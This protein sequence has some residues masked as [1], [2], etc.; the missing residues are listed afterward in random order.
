[1]VRRALL[2]GLTG[3]AVLCW[4]PSSAGA[5]LAFNSARCD[6]GGFS[7]GILTNG[8]CYAG[9]FR[10]R[11]DGTHQKRLTTGGATAENHPQ[12]SPNFG[13]Y[14][15]AWSPDG[16][17]VLFARRTGNFTYRLWTVG[18]NG[19]NEQEFAA[20]PPP[21]FAS[22]EF[23]S[24]APQGDRIA[25]VAGGDD[26]PG[27]DPGHPL[28]VS[29]TDGSN[30]V[31]LTPDGWD[32]TSPD[33]T[34]DGR[35]IIF[36]GFPQGQGSSTLDYGLY[37]VDADGSNLHPLTFM[38]DLLIAANG[39]SISPDGKYLA[40]TRSG[41]V[42]TMRL[43]DGEVVNRSHTDAITPTWSPVGP[44]IFFQGYPGNPGN[45][46]QLFS[47]D[48]SDGTENALTTPAESGSAPDWG[49]P[50]DDGPTVHGVTD[51]AAPSVVTPGDLPSAG[52]ASFGNARVS[53]A[54][55]KLSKIRFLAVDKTGIRRIDVA[56]GRRVNGGCR[57]V[58]GGGKLGAVRSCSR[59]R[60]Y[61]VKSIGA[62]RRRTDDLA[63]G[64]YEVR[65]RTTDVKGHRTKHPRRHLVKVR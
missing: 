19:S 35:H 62:W 10:M 64:T 25:F 13:D 12:G 31:K 63:K 18:A 55:T 7:G 29:G 21:G 57:F 5:E 6:Q 59:P 4:L 43:A 39:M 47:V 42:Y 44:T 17:S 22:Q 60:Y 15:P 46:S 11:D 3:L 16:K 1:V 27:E 20:G 40:F 37:Q 38:G 53:A 36:F 45:A 51:R 65:F 23:P 24:W 48:I 49:D 54:G 58:K 8:G 52:A 61:R 33:W 30:P 26:S 14:Y 28:F 32:V 50:G 2:I 9:V 41:G 34:P 56:I